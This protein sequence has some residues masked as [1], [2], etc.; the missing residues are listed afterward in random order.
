MDSDA[1]GASEVGQHPVDIQQRGRLHDPGDHQVPE[2]RVGDD[3][4]PELVEH[5]GQGVEQGPAAGA[6]DLRARRRAPAPTRGRGEQ[7]R[8]GRR[9]GHRPHALRDGHAQVQNA[10]GVIGEQVPGL[11]QQ[12]PELGLVARGPDVPHDPP[13]PVDGLSDLHGRGPRGRAHRPNPRHHPEPTDP[14]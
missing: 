8:R 10:L 4:E 3:V 1:D 11:G 13:A 5:R 12:Q 7:R 2:A 6:Q 9:R 14:N